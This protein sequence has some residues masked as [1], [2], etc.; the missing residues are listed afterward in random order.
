M[1]NGPD[2]ICCYC[3]TLTHEPYNG[4]FFSQCFRSLFL[5]L[6]ARGGCSRGGRRL[7]LSIRDEKEHCG[8]VLASVRLVAAI[9]TFALQLDDLACLHS[10]EA[11]VAQ[12]GALET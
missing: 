1:P 8:L 3:C 6:L 10:A 12:G 7:G 9:E 11:G 5:F 2:S 4:G